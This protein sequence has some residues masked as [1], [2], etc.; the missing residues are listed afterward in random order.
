VV[1]RGQALRL[2]RLDYFDDIRM[3]EPAATVQMAHFRA[4]ASM[5]LFGY[6]FATDP[7]KNQAFSTKFETWG[8]VFD[9]SQRG[10]GS[11]FVLNKDTRIEAITADTNAIFKEKRPA[12][13]GSV[14]SQRRVFRT[15]YRAATGVWRPMQ[16][17]WVGAIAVG[18]DSCSP[19]PGFVRAALSWLVTW[20]LFSSATLVST[21][22]I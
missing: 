17:G 12:P 11:A 5:K 16:C 20:F 8:A 14:Y 15:L 18:K 10:T 4:E 9:L 13:G 21:T 2:C 7:K 1:R 3:L 22:P 19:L 6:T